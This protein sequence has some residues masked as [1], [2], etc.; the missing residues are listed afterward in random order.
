MRKLS[1]ILGLL[2]PFA[3]FAASSVV[4]KPQPPKAGAPAPA[5]GVKV[6][7]FVAGTTWTFQNVA[8]P[9]LPDEKL[10][11]VSPQ[12]AKQVVIAVTAIDTKGADTVVSL[13]ETV[14]VEVTIPGVN[15]KEPTRKTNDRKVLSSVTCNA[16]KF[17]ISPNSFLFGGDPGGFLNMEFDKVER[18]KGGWTLTNGTIGEGEFREDVTA[19]WTRKATPNTGATDGSGTLELERKFVPQAPEQII[20]KAGNWKAEKLGFVTTGRITLD[21]AHPENK[22]MEMPAGWT[23]QLWLVDG[24]GLVQVI[25]GYSHMYQ[26]VEISPK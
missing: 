5:C 7:P 13:E 3:P 9:T 16:K 11:K 2:A 10:Q 19:H 6:L 26:L 17:E 4:A 22:P 8:S 24:V 20:T 15:G 14:T 25:N 1:L 23:T 12:P 21:K 18:P